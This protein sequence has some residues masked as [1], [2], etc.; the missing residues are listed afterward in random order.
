MNVGGRSFCASDEI[1]STHDRLYSSVCKKLSNHSFFA[2]LSF[3]AESD[4]MI[5]MNKYA[6]RSS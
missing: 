1:R 6:F 2:S 5:W 3:P 4:Y